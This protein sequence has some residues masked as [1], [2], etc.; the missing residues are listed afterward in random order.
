VP[1]AI[2]VHP[3]GPDEVVEAE[4][5]ATMNR[6]ETPGC[7]RVG[8]VIVVPVPELDPVLATVRLPAHSS[9]SARELAVVPD[10]VTVT[11]VAPDPPLPRQ[12]SVSVP[13]EAKAMSLVQVYDV[14][15]VVEMDE[16]LWSVV[17]RTMRVLPAVVEVTVRA[18]VD[19]EDT[20]RVTSWTGVAMCYSS[21]E[22]MT[23][24]VR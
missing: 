10:R 20:A 22:A 23:T 21:P 17:Q 16:T 5:P 4:R 11:V 19:P 1:E 18:I 13:P 12:I 7:V 14:P 24:L 3:T 6:A 9:T 15:P 8:E 2:A